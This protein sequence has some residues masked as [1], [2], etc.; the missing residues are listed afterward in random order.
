VRAL[1]MAL[2]ETYGSRMP[3]SNRVQRENP[4]SSLADSVARRRA[5]IAASIPALKQAQAARDR[6][7]YERVAARTVAEW[8]ALRGLYERMAATP[9]LKAQVQRA[10]ERVL[11]VSAH[12]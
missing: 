8:E 9:Q 4:D 7:A 6:A 11:T 3:V 5:A 10:H 1:G 12:H 2:A